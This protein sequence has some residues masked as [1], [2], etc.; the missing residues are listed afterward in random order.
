MRWNRPALFAASLALALLAFRWPMIFEN[1]Q[2]N[3]PDESQM[4][5]G[6]IVLKSDPIFWKSVDG[7]THGPLVQLPLAAL[8]ALGVRLD[9]TNARLVSTVLVWATLLFVWLTLRVPFGDGL[10]RVL[11]VPV[12]VFE[13]TTDFF[14]FNQYS[15]E[16][17]PMA[18]LAAATWLV[19]EETI[20][21]SVP[22]KWRLGVIGILLGA[23]PFAK[24]QGAPIGV[25]LGAMGLIL[26]LANREMT[27][28]ERGRSCAWLV[29]GALVVPTVVGVMVVAYDIRHDFW[30]TYIQT[31]LL[32]ASAHSFEF[33]EGV[34]NL[35]SL[36]NHPVSFREFYEPLVVL[37]IGSAVGCLFLGRSGNLRFMALVGGLLVVSAYATIAP[38]RQYTHYV[39]F[40]IAPLTLSAGAFIGTIYQHCERRFRSRGIRR[41]ALVSLCSATAFIL[42]A[43]SQLVHRY[44][45]GE[46][47]R[48][49]LFSTTR[50]K[51]PGSAVARIV[52]DLTGEKDYVA[53]W[54]W[55]PRYLVEANRMHATREAHS[56][57]ELFPSPVR[58]YYRT[59]YMNDLRRK[60]PAIFVDVTGEGSFYFEDRSKYSHETFPELADE[61]ALNY[62][63]LAEI[64][65]DRIYLRNDRD[66]SAAAA[67]R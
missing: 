18:L 45:Y 1:R 24:L 56:A 46:P 14:D 26:I 35:I 66:G 7:T 15:S 61:I 29:G 40:L 51:L 23:V 32:Y 59:R 6:A 5:A 54:G 67:L 21:R 11:T 53:M 34:R 25:W 13:I 39:Q 55:E 42:V 36:V 64:G 2:L 12:A 22:V 62:H 57:L 16:H 52:R 41:F 3:N 63:L 37:M 49:G 19:V 17:V 28:R 50:G 10:A 48:V 65:A 8:G 44:T 58:D 27:W 47:D 33:H 60:N 38:N 9:Y 4:I 31:N 20:G 43:G 30:V